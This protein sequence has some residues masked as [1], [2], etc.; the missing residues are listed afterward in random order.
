MNCEEAKLKF[1]DN[2]RHDSPDKPALDFEFQAHLVDCPAC[3]EEWNL[4]RSA[5]ETLDLLPVP[6][7]SRA[8]RDRFYQALE[9]YDRAHHQER[10]VKPKQA[11]RW[12]A[13]WPM[14]PGLQFGLSA[15]LLVVGI[16]AGYEL[17][18]RERSHAEV[19]QLR[20]EVSN[21]RQL[22]TLSLL[23]QQSASDRLRGV[24]WSY[25]VEQSDTEVLSALLHAVNQDQNVSVRLAAVDALRNFGDSP[26]ARKGIT[27]SLLKQSSPMLQIALVDLL[28]E[29][30]ERP[31]VQAI[32]MLLATPDL[33]PSVKKKVEWALQQLG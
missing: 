18:G 3:R 26:V 8:V 11:S 27:Q 28:V 13:W 6:E 21:M 12:L 14:H 17:G 2:L 24:S 9:T 32:R 16:T 15:M 20:G 25:R 33:D 31:A 7:P 10:A 30:H 4:A 23:Q 19:S 1:A 22:V 5:W 29:L